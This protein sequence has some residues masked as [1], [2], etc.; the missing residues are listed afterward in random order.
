MIAF[1]VVVSDVFTNAWCPQN[2]RD[3]LSGLAV[4]EIEGSVQPGTGLHDAGGAVV[5]GG[6]PA[7]NQ[8]IQEGGGCKCNP[9]EKTGEIVQRAQDKARLEARRRWRASAF[10][11]ANSWSKFGAEPSTLPRWPFHRRRHLSR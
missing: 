8:D 1:G 2:H 9:A 5:V 10:L 3:E 7:A 6:N 4:I 11:S